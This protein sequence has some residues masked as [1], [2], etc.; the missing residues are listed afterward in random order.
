MGPLFKT[1]R[2][3]LPLRFLVHPLASLLLVIFLTSNA[4][5]SPSQTFDITVTYYDTPAWARTLG[6]GFQIFESPSNTWA[7]PQ[8]WQ[9]TTARA[10]AGGALSPGETVYQVTIP[11]TDL[12]DVYI[13][14]SGS[15]SGSSSGAPST[16]IFVAE[17]P[18][19]WVPDATA[20]AYGPPWIS[21]SGINSGLSLSGDLEIINGYDDQ[22]G[23]SHPWVVGTWEI[24]PDPVPEPA[25]LLLV[26]AGLMGLGLARVRR[27]E[28]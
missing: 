27:R 13:N 2:K 28:S 4:Q 25:S 26:G 6:I 17:P 19:G 21:L 16:S 18:T 23:T 15:F 8:M 3:A 22:I 5:A 14:G 24:T 1:V 12:S 11:V 9:G 10:S 20:W 7:T